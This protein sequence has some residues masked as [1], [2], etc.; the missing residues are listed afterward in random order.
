MSVIRKLAATASLVGL[1]LVS[2]GVHGCPV[3]D[4]DPEL[5][6]GEYP[7]AIAAILEGGLRIL[8]EIAQPAI[9]PQRIQVGLPV[10]FS[11][12]GQEQIGAL[13]I[14]E[15]LVGAFERKFNILRTD[16][17]RFYIDFNNS[18]TFDSNEI[19]GELVS[20]DNG[21]T[22]ESAAP[23]Q[24]NITYPEDSH[25]TAGL[26]SFVI[27]L[28]ILPPL[29]GLDEFAFNVPIDIFFDDLSLQVHRNLL[30]LINAHVLPHIPFGADNLLTIENL[31]EVNNPH[32]QPV[33]VDFAFFEVATGAVLPVEINQILDSD[34][35]FVVP[36]Y[37]SLQLEVRG[38]G[39][40]TAA[41]SNPNLEVNDNGGD[42]QVAW[43][44]VRGSQ[45]VS[46]STIY[47]TFENER[48]ASRGSQL[49]G[50]AAPIRTLAGEAGIRASEVSTSHVLNVSRTAEGF[51]TAFAFV[52]PTDQ[53][54]NL[55]ISLKDS[56]EV[57]VAQ[58]SLALAPGT[59]TA[60]FVLPFFELDTDVFSGSA[61]VVS[62]TD[63][64]GMSLRTQRGIQRS[65]LSSGSFAAGGN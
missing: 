37:S 52:N 35:R 33:D 53:T 47:S 18:G 62:D 39:D 1:T 50:P 59:Q 48:A 46:V 65:S 60:Q 5:E 40:N 16:E 8:V 17:T 54:A 10:P 21:L 58:K 64:A 55:T 28:D 45:P 31:I 32:G 41:D 26:F 13:I 30:L 15:D 3:L 51:D 38:G 56:Q 61:V 43:A 7:L 34:H 44:L 63:V 29:T 24:L 49:Q 20:S 6:P 25:S 57:E 2:L 11:S 36:A 27:D 12:F 4:G 42:L 22:G 14:N 23:T 9:T 19:S